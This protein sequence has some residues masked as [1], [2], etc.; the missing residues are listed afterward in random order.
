MRKLLLSA[1]LIALATSSNAAIVNDHVTFDATNFASAFGQTPPVLD[2]SGSFDITFDDSIDHTDI[3]AGIT[4]GVINVAAGQFGFTY[5]SSTS[6]PPSG[7]FQDEL[8][9]GG[10]LN[11]AAIVI[12][13]PPTDDFWLHILNFP[14]APEFQQVG[15]SQTSLNNENLFFTGNLTDGSVTVTP[16]EGV[17]ETSTWVMMLLGFSGLG[18]GYRKSRR[19]ARTI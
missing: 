6:S 4:N 14:T 11:G 3:T 13:N 12:Y 15:Y 16:I 5:Y 17:P 7:F 9:V 8:V 10:I 18:L 1:A 19:T 2:V